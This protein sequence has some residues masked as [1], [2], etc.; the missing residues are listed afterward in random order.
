MARIDNAD[1]SIAIE[2]VDTRYFTSWKDGIIY[3]DNMP[4]EDLTTKLERW[5][6]VK[7]TYKNEKPKQLHFSGALENSRDIQFLLNLISQTT[8]VKFEVKDKLITVE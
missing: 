7:I 2:T 5:Y 8:H 4:L 3:F 6:S 1:Q